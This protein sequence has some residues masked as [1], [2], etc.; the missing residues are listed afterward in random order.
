MPSPSRLSWDDE[1]TV[2]AAPERVFPLLCPVR[3]YDWIPTWSCQMIHSRSGVA[4][5]GCVF[6]T[7]VPGGGKMTWVVSVY[8]PPRRIEFTCVAPE[9]FAM[10]LKLSLASDGAER[11]TLRWRREFLSLGEAGDRHLAE[12]RTEA[13]HRESMALLERNLREYLAGTA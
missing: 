3:E 2:A 1:M 8:E 7:P 11:T 10:R 12:H 5:D 4:E 6:Q 9:L 13:A